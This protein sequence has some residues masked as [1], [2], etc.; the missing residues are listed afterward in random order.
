VQENKWRAARYGLDAIIIRDADNTEVHVVDDV[1][2]LLVRLGPTARSL[3]CTRELA[4]ISD[5]LAAGA[6]Y[7]RM[8]AAVDRNGTGDL[9]AAVREM[10]VH[11]PA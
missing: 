11:A 9:R 1:N 3:G 4:G 7:Q 10:V 5:I 2:E 8:R 6:G